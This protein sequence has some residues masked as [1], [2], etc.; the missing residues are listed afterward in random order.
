MCEG[1]AGH[2]EGCPDLEEGEREGG[3]GGL[4]G[5]GDDKEAGA[6]GAAGGGP[7]SGRGREVQAR[8]SWRPGEAGPW[9]GAGVLEVEPGGGCPTLPGKPGS[10]GP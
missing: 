1:Q 2:G 10:P 3:M 7:G 9:E 4:G 5:E 8:E 6:G